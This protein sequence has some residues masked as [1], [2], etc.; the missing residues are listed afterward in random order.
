MHCDPG[1]FGLSHYSGDATMDLGLMEYFL[2]ESWL[3]FVC[4]FAAK[5]KSNKNTERPNRWAEFL[6]KVLLCAETEALNRLIPRAQMGRNC[7]QGAAVN[8]LPFSELI[9][10]KV[11]G[12]SSL[13]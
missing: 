8:Y 13:V 9:T 4:I 11:G 3:N 10:R 1:A 2:A 5:K 6:I 12:F 7:F